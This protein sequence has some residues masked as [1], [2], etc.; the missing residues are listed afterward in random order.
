VTKPFGI[1]ELMA[2]LRAALRTRSAVEEAPTMETA[3]FTL[4]LAAR[5]AGRGTR[6]IRLTA[7]EWQAVEVL[8][9][10]PGRLI[11]HAQLL[12]RVWG[13]T[14]TKNN[15]VR[16]Y[17]LSIRRKLEPDP[18]HPR[19]FLT[20]HRS[21]VRFDPQGRRRGRRLRRERRG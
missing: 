1:A 5:R 21:G 6:E 15:Y 9:R 4:D 12:E 11:T 13:I 2:R 3:D 19:Y 18:A 14:D 17:L 10:N 8:A 20:E 16:V 7:T